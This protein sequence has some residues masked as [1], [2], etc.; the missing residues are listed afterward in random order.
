MKFFVVAAFQVAARI[1]KIL[2]YRILISF[3]VP[4]LKTPA[5]PAWKILANTVNDLLTFLF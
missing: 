5:D 2:V 4:E 1:R 3:L